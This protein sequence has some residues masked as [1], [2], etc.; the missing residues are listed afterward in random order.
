MK[1]RATI[2]DIKRFAV[3]D[4]PGIRTT[5]F[6]KGCPLRC[7]WCHNPE[8]L[9]SAPQLMHE[10]AKC[11][12]CG[13][14]RVPCGH[15]DCAPWERCLH[16]CPQNALKVAGRT[17]T[18]DELADVLLRDAEFLRSVGGGV[19]FSGGEPLMQAEFLAALMPRLVGLH[20]CIETCGYAAGERFAAVLDG[21]DFVLF[22]LKLADSVEHVRRTGVPNEPIHANLARLRASGKPFILRVPLI[23][24]ITD[25]E[26]NLRGLAALAGH[27]P[28]ELLP[29][30]RLAGAKY[31]Q[32]GMVYPLGEIEGAPRADA[33]D[34]FQNAVMR[35]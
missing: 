28:V 30:N 14:C 20:L 6:F 7:A 2:F 19:T 16:V 34:F 3:G 29:C 5:V 21:M 24:G 31:P 32:A 17:V 4:G 18:A 8:G 27:D 9:D 12:G 10:A 22:D 33:A 15:D 26:E 11:T 25:T 13:L 1:D 35:K 23:P